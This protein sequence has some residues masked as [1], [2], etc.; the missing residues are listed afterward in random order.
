MSA[1]QPIELKARPRQSVE[2][3][4]RSVPS[5][6]LSA[7]RLLLVGVAIAAIAGASG[8]GWHYWTTGRFEVSTDDAYVGAD[9]TII[10][11]KVGGYLRGVSVRDNQ[12]VKTGQVLA[13]IDDRDY[14]VALAQA[15][16]DVAAAQAEIDNISATIERQQAVI[17][18]AAGTVAVDNAALTFA[19][20]DY[21]RYADL[22]SRGAGTVQMAQQSTSKRD[23]AGAM[24]ARDTA[25]LKEAQ[26]QT[27]VLQAQ[28]AQANATL[29][30]RRANAQ[31]AELNLGYT[32]I[33]AP[34]DGVIGDRTLRVGQFVQAGTDLMAIVPIQHVYIVANFKE[35][36]LTNVQK[37]QPVEVEVDTFPRVRFE[38][39]VDSIAPASGQVFA[40]LPPDNA[41]GNFT[42]VVQRIPVKIA[43]DNQT[44]NVARLRPGM[45]VV[46]VVN[47]KKAARQDSQ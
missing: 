6:R 41:T 17:A 32:T 40:L 19:K 9:S 5:R 2:T 13:K 47:T 38:G 44:D 4:A 24:L 39:H 36:Q 29:E 1:A 23:A 15:R 34:V 10:A 8:Y 28:L 35:T 31:Q 20:Q 18:Q 7:R 42:K 22:A 11:P 25:A 30:H 14:V 46:P 16:A 3:V 45:S 26:Q 12:P 21:A 43:L 27:S 37:G 33:K